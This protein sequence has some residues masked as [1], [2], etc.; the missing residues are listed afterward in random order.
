MLPDRISKRRLGHADVTRAWGSHAKE[1]AWGNVRVTWNRS[2][3]DVKVSC[4]K[5]RTLGLESHL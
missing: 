1:T 4:S 2:L 3:G 5:A